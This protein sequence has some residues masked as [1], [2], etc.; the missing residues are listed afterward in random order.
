MLGT[1]HAAPH[2]VQPSDSVLQLLRVD[3]PAELRVAALRLL[4]ELCRVPVVGVQL[5]ALQAA[6]L[7]ARLLVQP[8]G[9][10]T[11]RL[12]ALRT[13]AQLA[14]HHDACEALM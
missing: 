4:A 7:L 5:G 6:P 14:T 10:H 8:E 11:E 9:T 3:P 1:N 13:L 12:L 2:T